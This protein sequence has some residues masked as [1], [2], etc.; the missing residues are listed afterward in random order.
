[1]TKRNR[2]TQR[3][4]TPEPVT[5]AAVTF[6]LAAAGLPNQ[7]PLE[8]LVSALDGVR[9]GRGTIYRALDEM[10][11]HL[12]LLDRAQKAVGELRAVL[13]P[14]LLHLHP[15]TNDGTS[16]LARAALGDEEAWN[17]ARRAFVQVWKMH[18][19][20]VDLPSSKAIEKFED[21]HVAADVIFQTVR[22][23]A[24]GGSSSRTSRLTEFVRLALERT[25]HGDHTVEGIETALLRKEN[26][27]AER[28]AVRAY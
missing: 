18:E 11:G 20:L 6:L 8:T 7:A 13:P 28:S 2:A 16:L 9:R 15:E 1:M 24:G 25:G 17:E 23:Y 14:I 27:K 19:A 21:W 10:T 5:D 3:L 12:S 22:A 26:R 4:V